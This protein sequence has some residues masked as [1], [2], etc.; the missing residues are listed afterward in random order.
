MPTLRPRLAV[1]AAALVLG[2]LAGCGTDDPA[3]AG[4][5]T[6]PAPQ[7]TTAAPSTPAATTP[8]GDDVQA[9]V[10]ALRAF[11]AYQRTHTGDRH[12][13]PE[14]RTLKDELERTARAVNRTDL[15][16]GENSAVTGP[17]MSV[18]AGEAVRIGQQVVHRDATATD[19]DLDLDGDALTWQIEFSDGDEVT[20]HADT[21]E[22][23]DR[24]VAD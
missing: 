4:T 12:D 21:G 8:A 7:P 9:F 18:P 14:F 2:L 1:P 23:L 3:P 22:V 5:A 17:G 13:D 24:D 11:V 10:T 6:T 15:W 16:L 19:V 20:V